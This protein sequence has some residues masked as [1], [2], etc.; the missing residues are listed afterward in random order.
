MAHWE[1]RF[2]DRIHRVS[3]EQ[4]V[5]DVP[6]ALANILAFLGADWDDAVMRDAD[7]PG[8][9]RTASVW[10][11]RQP[12]HSR[13]VARWQHYDEIAP[14]FFTRLSAIDGEYG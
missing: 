3:Y 9:V 7:N 11:A 6:G 10:Q 4:L 5:N 1:G 12:V 8:V 2:T 13:S 14:D